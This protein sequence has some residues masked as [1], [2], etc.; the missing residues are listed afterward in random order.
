MYMKGFTAPEVELSNTQSLPSRDCYN[1]LRWLRFT[2]MRLCRVYTASTHY[3][4]RYGSVL[5]VSAP[6]LLD[7]ITAPAA[8][9]GPF[10]QALGLGSRFVCLGSCGGREV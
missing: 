10:R 6:K 5:H 3:P 1:S 7:P 9:A 8:R 4:S 2:V